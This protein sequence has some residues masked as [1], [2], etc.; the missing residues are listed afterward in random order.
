MP[1]GGACKFPLWRITELNTKLLPGGAAAFV[2][3]LQAPCVFAM[4]YAQSTFDSDTDGWVVVDTPDPGPDVPPTIIDTFMPA[5]D[6]TGGNPGGCITLEDPQAGPV[7]FWRAP[8]KF[9]GDKL[10]AY[11]GVLGFDVRDT[12]SPSYFLYPDVLLTGGGITLAYSL[13]APQ[14]YPLDGTFRRYRI[15]LVAHGW[16]N[17]A[18]DEPATDAE[19]ATV[20]SS[21]DDLLIRAEFLSDTDTF[22]LDNVILQD[23]HIF[24][25]DFED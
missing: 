2:L 11:P 22:S 10:M 1:R 8:P 5:Y 9:L 4:D 20:L 12:S 14:E 6:A 13:I 16:R 23:D 3:F 25:D 7:S 17:L 18:T 21:L 24:D 15:G 19:M